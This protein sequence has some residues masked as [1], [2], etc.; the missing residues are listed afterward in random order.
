LIPSIRSGYLGQERGRVR[1]NP[2]QRRDQHRL[3]EREGAIAIPPYLDVGVP[4]LLPQ[5]GD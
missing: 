2:G 3:I 4:N 5:C 1:L